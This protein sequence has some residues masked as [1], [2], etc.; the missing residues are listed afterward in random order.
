LPEWMIRTGARPYTL[1]LEEGIQYVWDTYGTTVEVEL[2][3]D[4]EDGLNDA[5]SLGVAKF[6]VP[7][8]F[9][10]EDG[11]EICTLAPETEPAAGV[12]GVGW[13]GWENFRAQEE[14]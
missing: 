2:I 8:V 11:D 1:T 9:V 14:G 5:T 7:V 3:R 6:T 12:I 10:D 4:G 13:S